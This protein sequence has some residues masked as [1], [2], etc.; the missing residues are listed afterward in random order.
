MKTLFLTCCLLCCF[1]DAFSQKTGTIAEG[2][3]AKEWFTRAKNTL[4]QLRV[5]S[6]ELAAMKPQPLPPKFM[7]TLQKYDWVQVGNLWYK[8]NAYTNAN[9]ECCQ[10][11][12]QRYTSTFKQYSLGC[13]SSPL[14]GSKIIYEQYTA[15][16]TMKLT[17]IGGKN[18]LQAIRTGKA[19]EYIHLISYQNG[20]LIYD[21]TRDSSPQSI[22]SNMRF[23]RVYV[24]QPK[25][26]SMDE[27]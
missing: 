16:P 10:L 11:H 5:Q 20:I 7:D 24:A 19:T 22:Q 6:L 18:F 1:A 8:N 15:A 3:F 26:F 21:V 23:R 25:Y 2:D 17:Q 13:L 9:D 12:L 27:D 14:S 4:S